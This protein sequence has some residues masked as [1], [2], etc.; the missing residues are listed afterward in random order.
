MRFSV[1]W[2]LFY[3]SSNFSVSKL[4]ISTAFFKSITVATSSDRMNTRWFLSRR[5]QVQTTVGSRVCLAVWQMQ[6]IPNLKTSLS[7][8]VSN[9]IRLKRLPVQKIRE[10]DSEQ[11]FMWHGNR[12]NYT[13]FIFR[14]W[15][16]TQTVLPPSGLR[17]NR[18]GVAVTWS[19][20]RR[21]GVTVMQAYSI[22][23]L[24]HVSSTWR[25]WWRVTEN[26]QRPRFTTC[27][28]YFSASSLTVRGRG[29]CCESTNSPP[30]I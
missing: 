8:V 16:Q 1:E 12:T 18:L 10:A 17:Y 26:V 23:P 19:A 13:S 29:F 6:W 11:V 9:A 2:S 3:E 25:T 22:T 21:I 28:K 30:L 27:E 4:L 14:H 24:T 7:R 5:V 15:F 20:V